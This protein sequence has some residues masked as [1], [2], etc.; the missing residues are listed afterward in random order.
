MKEEIQKDLITEGE[1]VFIYSYSIQSSI[2][3]GIIEWDGST[4]N[5]SLLM[6]QIDA[7]NP[8]TTYP[9]IHY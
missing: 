6:S 8:Y 3:I 7:W 9:T 4:Y 2:H 1:V 5:D